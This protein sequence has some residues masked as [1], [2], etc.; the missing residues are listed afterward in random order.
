M[1]IPAGSKHYDIGAGTTS[2]ILTGHTA[3]KPKRVDVRRKAPNAAGDS[4]YYVKVT[5]GVTQADGTIKNDVTEF[6]KRT[7]AASVLAD[8]QACNNALRSILASANFDSDV[9]VSLSLPSAS[10]IAP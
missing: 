4:Y 3:V 7:T 10:D 9:G 5:T 6:S 8:T 1:L 2:F